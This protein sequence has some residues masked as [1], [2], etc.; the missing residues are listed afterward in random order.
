MDQKGQS[1]LLV[2]F[3][4]TLEI[5]YDVGGKT[6]Q[7]TYWLG[8]PASKLKNLGNPVAPGVDPW[9]GRFAVLEPCPRISPKK[10]LH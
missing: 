5:V 10:G 1:G 8:L 3:P 6:E 2:D 9:A 4:N 7:L